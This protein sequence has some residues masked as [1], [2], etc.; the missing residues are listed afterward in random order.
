[1]EQPDYFFFAAFLAAG[2]AAGAAAAAFFAAGLAAGFAALAA[3][4]L[5]ALAVF[6]A[7]SI[8]HAVWLRMGPSP[9]G[10]GR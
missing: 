2:F 10:S 6:V 7:M 4:G 9:E 8:I 5:E 3:A 1:M